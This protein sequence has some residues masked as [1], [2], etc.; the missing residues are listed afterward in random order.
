M[1]RYLEDFEPGQRFA[2]GSLLIETA[3]IK[4]FATEFDPQPFHIDEDSAR[5][6]FFKG[7]AASGCIPRR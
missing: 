6:S 1:V 2:S 4:S 7:L 3:R 5:D